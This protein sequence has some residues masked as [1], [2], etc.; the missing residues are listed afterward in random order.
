M[1]KLF[2]NQP[3]FSS[4]EW[5][6]TLGRL[7]QRRTVALT[8]DDGPTPE[9]TPQILELLKQ[10]GVPATFFVS[11]ERGARAPHLIQAILDHGHD[12]YA[13]GWSHI[14][15]QHEPP[16]VLYDEMERTERL[17]ATY[18]PTPSPYLVRLP[19]GSGA[20]DVATHRAITAWRPASQLALW[21]YTVKDHLIAAEEDNIVDI[22][23]RCKAEVD[24]LLARRRL[25]GA[26]LLLHE[27]PYDVSADLNER[28]A[29]IILRHLL[30]G[31]E[32]RG[33]AVSR[34]SPIP[35]P[36]LLSRYVLTASV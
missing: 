8:I 17:L 22:E 34:L 36:S 27:T 1:G 4:G 33:L 23:L 15:L 16:E 29:P 11:G 12:V 21:T 18:R 14:R 19:Y 10:H 2:R 13:H 24:K 30:V 32:A 20:R 7:P 3:T 28:V 35:E 26:I 9:T 25:G 31:L 6:P 5:L